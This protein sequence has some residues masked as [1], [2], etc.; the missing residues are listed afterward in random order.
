LVSSFSNICLIDS[1]ELMLLLLVLVVFIVGIFSLH[2]NYL[3]INLLLLLIII[4]ITLSETPLYS[5]DIDITGQKAKQTATQY[6]QRV[7]Q[8]ITY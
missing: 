8:C 1:D 4:I 7:E 2:A 6:H 5:D 3:N